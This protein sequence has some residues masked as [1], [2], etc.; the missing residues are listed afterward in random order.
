M[1]DA[2]PASEKDVATGAPFLENWVGLMCVGK[3][4]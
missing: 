3:D 2:I 1:M 4:F